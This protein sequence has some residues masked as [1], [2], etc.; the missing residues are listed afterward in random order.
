MQNHRCRAIRLVIAK[1]QTWQ[2]KHSMTI[3]NAFFSFLSCCWYLS[4]DPD[5]YKYAPLGCTFV[6]VAMLASTSAMLSGAC[7]VWIN[8]RAAHLPSWD[9]QFRFATMTKILM[10]I[11]KLYLISSRFKQDIG[12]YSNNT[13]ED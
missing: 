12:L 10:F 6:T 1:M 3:A 4:F 5:A 8:K 7:A 13:P 11:C 9:V 2:G